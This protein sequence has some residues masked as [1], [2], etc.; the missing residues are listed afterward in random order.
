[1]DSHSRETRSPKHSPRAVLQ[2][3]DHFSLLCFS[4]PHPHALFFP[5]F[6]PAWPRFLTWRDLARL[7]C[8]HQRFCIGLF[9]IFAAACE[10]DGWN[11]CIQATVTLV[12]LFSAQNVFSLAVC[13][14][15]SHGEN[16]IGIFTQHCWFTVLHI[17]VNI[18]HNAVVKANYT[19][20][21]KAPLLPL[22]APIR[23]C[24][25]HG[26]FSAQKVLYYGKRF[27]RILKSWKNGS[28]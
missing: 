27:F 4:C 6:P 5:S 17:Q 2:F 16:M 14:P 21:N 12:F 24:N 13:P 23:T 9:S 15:Q 19:P 10:F 3:I 8:Y 7:C 18:V 26:T 28:V 1:M 25:I 20:K 22:M 11:V